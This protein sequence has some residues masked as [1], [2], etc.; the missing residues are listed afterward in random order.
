MPVAIKCGNAYPQ[1][2]NSMAAGMAIE[3]LK[4]SAIIAESV[5]EQENALVPTR[6]AFIGQALSELGDFALSGLPDGYAE[7]GVYGAPTSEG[8]GGYGYVIKR[9][10]NKE[11]N[12]SIAFSYETYLLADGKENTAENVLALSGFGGSELEVNG[13]PGLISADG[14]RIEWVDTERSMR[15]LIHSETV[16][17]EELYALANSAR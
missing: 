9:Y 17:G 6:A 12:S 13:L 4:R 8:G 2:A 7:A 3:H 14:T 1:S 5:A 11:T 10:E 15:F 16:K